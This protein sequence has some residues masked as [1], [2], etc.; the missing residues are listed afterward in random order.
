MES[1]RAFVPLDEMA[2]K[3]IERVVP[4]ILEKYVILIYSDGSYSQIRACGGEID[5]S[6]ISYDEYHD[7]TDAEF[8][9]LG[10]YTAEDIAEHRRKLDEMR[11]ARER[12]EDVRRYEYLK[13]KL[14][15]TS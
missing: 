7:F 3:T 11:R 12:E 6:P 14:G 4:D 8:I 10:L 13:N 9:D 5:V 1:R 15:I 2:G